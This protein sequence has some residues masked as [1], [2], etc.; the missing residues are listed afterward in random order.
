MRMNGFSKFLLAVHKL[1]L[2]IF[3]FALFMKRLSV[4]ITINGKWNGLQPFKLLEIDP[5]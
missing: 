5:P 4:V 3:L 2:T 1:Q